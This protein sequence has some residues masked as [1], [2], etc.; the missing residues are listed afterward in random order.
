MIEQV[1]ISYHVYNKV[2]GE[3]KNPFKPERS[4]GGSSGGEAGLVATRCVPFGLGS[5]LGGSIRIPPEFNG[6]Y[7]FKSTSE[8]ISMLGSKGI[9]KDNFSPFLSPGGRMK[10]TLGPITGSLDDLVLGMRVLLHK[11]AHRY[12]P[13]VAPTPFREELYRSSQVGAGK[14]LGYI[15]SLPTV[16]ASPAAQRAVKIAK[17]ILEKRGFELV[18]FE[19]TK[20]DLLSYNEV[21]NGLVG[22]YNALPTFQTMVEN[23]EPWVPQYK[24]IAAML[25]YPWVFRALLSVGLK[26][27]GNK[28]IWEAVKSLRVQTRQELEALM[29]K[30]VQL[31]LKMKETWDNL[32]IEGLIMPNYPIPAFQSANVEHLGAFRDYQIAWSLLHYPCGV[33]PV[34]QVRDSEA[35]YPDDGYNDIWTRAI[36]RDISTAA[37]LPVGIQ[38]VAR[39]WDD[40]VALGLM[41]VI[42][43]GVDPMD[44]PL[45]QMKLTSA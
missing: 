5:D 30:H 18:P 21:L 13:F 39:K 37:G 3:A 2:W 7:G 6:V 10:S 31:Q 4:T 22:N 26:A 43:E 45:P 19:F 24:G 41:K 36:Q 1:L 25:L 23:H 35:A 44:L 15:F 38:V 40:E 29:K 42:D 32:G 12:D 20:E 33:V 11:D 28:R 16:P 9:I 17:E 8:R 34:T 14:K 27:T